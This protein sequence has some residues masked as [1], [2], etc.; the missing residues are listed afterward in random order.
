MGLI[1]IFKKPL[2][3]GKNSSTEFYDLLFCDD[4]ERHK[5]QIKQPAI[6]PWG[7]LFSD[8]CTNEDLQA[9]ISD[10]QTESRV[11][12]LAYKKLV[13]RGQKPVKKELLAVIVEIGL[14]KGTDVLASYRDGTARYINQSGKII[15]WDVRD[16]RSDFLTSEL[17]YES[18]NIV[19]EIGPW[20]QQERLAPP[21]KGLARITFLV[22]D[23]LYFG[24]APMNDL[25]HDS[26]SGPTLNAA[27]LL[28]EHLAEKALHR[29]Q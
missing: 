3:P 9:L 10:P 23:G 14:E 27:I 13:L 5:R 8:A 2:S 22:S 17:F 1:S 21:G 29:N 6:Y 12:I 26:L 18:E 11:K 19:K 28:M 4:I 24:Q 16:S 20:D 25:F 7:V 15:A